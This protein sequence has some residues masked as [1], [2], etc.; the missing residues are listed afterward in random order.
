MEKVK[1]F[2]KGIKTES[3]KITWLSFSDTIKNSGIVFL[4]TVIIGAGVW[5]FDYGFRLLINVL[6]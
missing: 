4:T 3:K 5:V 2:F 1:V 6:S